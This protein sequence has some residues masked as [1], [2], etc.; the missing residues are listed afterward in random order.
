[1]PGHN[2]SDVF[3]LGLAAL[4]VYFQTRPADHRKTFGYQRAG[5]LAAFVNALTLVVFAAILLYESWVRLRNPEPVAETAML[6][7]A[8]AG[9]AMNLAIA[10]SIGRHGHDLNMR[11][12]WLHQLGDAASCVGIIIGA[13]VIRYTG[14]LAVDPILSI[15]IAILMAA[16][17]FGVLRDSL[18]ILLEGLPKGLRLA[19]VTR[20]LNS[21]AGVIDVHDL[22]IWNLGSEGAR[23]KLPR[24]DRGHAAVGQR[25]HPAPDQ[26][27]A[28]RSLRDS[29]HDDSVRGTCAARSPTFRARR[30]RTSIDIEN[31]R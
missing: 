19:D 14:W 26:R 31:G 10:F 18:N 15:L 21:V 17:A 1:M 25:F 30:R 9:L 5:V 7:V 29:P 24:V 2:F 16:S 3:A 13:L 6:L 20:D 23:A 12:A 4:G 8:A 22:H 28:V 27:A 11:A